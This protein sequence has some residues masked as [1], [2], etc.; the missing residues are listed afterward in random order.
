MKNFPLYDAFSR[1]YRHFNNELFQDKLPECVFVLQRR[2]SMQGYFMDDVWKEAE[3]EERRDEIAINPDMLTDQ[4]I[5]ETLST[6]VHEMCHLEQA[7]FGTPS[8][9]GY[10]NSEWAKM[11]ITVGLEP[12]PVNQ[13]KTPKTKKPRHTGY[14]LSH[15]IIP[16]GPFDKSVNKL[17][18]RDFKIPWVTKAKKRADRSKTK[19]TCPYCQLSAWAKPGISLICGTCRKSMPASSPKNYPNKDQTL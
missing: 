18:R 17:L 16:E 14:S 10:H 13:K 9:D 6:L 8:K 15:K 7:H 2:K 3:G 12:V 4:T 1:A 19:Y 5:K 11:M